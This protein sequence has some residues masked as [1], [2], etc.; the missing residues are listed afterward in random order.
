MD[1]DALEMVHSCG[2][3][4]HS[5]PLLLQTEM[6]VSTTQNNRSLLMIHRAGMEASDRESY[7]FSSTSK[8]KLPVFSA[9][10]W[11]CSRLLIRIMVVVL[12][13]FLARFA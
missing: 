8:L 1:L 10:I 5:I 2:H 3:A 11:S 12:D 9:Q 13:F 7:L 4:R 6:L